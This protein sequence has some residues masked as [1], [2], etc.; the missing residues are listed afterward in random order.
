MEV[1]L[2]CRKAH[3]AIEID[4]RQHLDDPDAYRRDRNKDLLLQENGWLVIRLLADDIAEKLDDL[5]DS[6]LRLLT[7]RLR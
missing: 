1:D 5:L 3:I 7:A 4:G 2:T 6:V